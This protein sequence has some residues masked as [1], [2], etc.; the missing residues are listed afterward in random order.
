M[1]PEDEATSSLDSVSEHHI[2]AALRPLP[3]G[4]TSIVL[5]H[6]LSTILAADQILVLDQGCLVNAGIHS[7]LFARA[8]RPPGCTS[9][10]SAPNTRR[11]G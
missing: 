5:A 6:R 10:S 1:D 4:R 3:H 9:S 11:G 2:Q 7:E 8:A